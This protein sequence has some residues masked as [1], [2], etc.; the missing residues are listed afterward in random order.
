MWDRFVLHSIES[1]FLNSGLSIKIKIKVVAFDLLSDQGVIFVR[2]KIWGR[3]WEFV[4]SSGLFYMNLVWVG[5]WWRR[6]A[7]RWRHRGR[8]KMSTNVRLG[9]LGFL[10]MVGPWLGLWFT[11][12]PIKGDVRVLMILSNQILVASLFSFLPIEEVKFLRCDF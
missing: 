9:I 7:W 2:R 12:N 1:V 11:Q 4:F 6:T 5:L 3:S 10:N 8:W